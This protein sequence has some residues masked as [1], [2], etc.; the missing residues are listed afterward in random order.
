M[1]TIKQVNMALKKAGIDAELC[2]GSGYFYFWGQDCSGWYTTSVYVN[3]L[4]AIPT[5]ERWINEYLSLKN[6]NV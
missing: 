6:S 1:I 2:K 4:N 5:V 3:R